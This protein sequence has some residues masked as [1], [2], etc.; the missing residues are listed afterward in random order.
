M[1]RSVSQQEF[2]AID[3]AK[4]EIKKEVSKYEKEKKK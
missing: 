3:N 2:F 4:S 1:N